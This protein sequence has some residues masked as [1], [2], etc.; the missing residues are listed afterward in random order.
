MSSNSK[1]NFK[2][3][4]LGFIGVP[5]LVS[6]PAAFVATATAGATEVRAWVASACAVR[7]AARRSSSCASAKSR[8]CSSRL[9][10]A[11]AATASSSAS[12]K[13]RGASKSEVPITGKR[14]RGVT[15]IGSS[16]SGPAPRAHGRDASRR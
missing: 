15:A 10:K 5:L 7:K 4:L 1:Y 2:T 12:R 6:I 16:H 13:R 3:L 9:K 14:R 8:P 11:S